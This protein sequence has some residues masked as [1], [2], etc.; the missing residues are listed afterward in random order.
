LS[1][2]DL[3]CW[4][5]KVWGRSASNT[6][7]NTR[8]CNGCRMDK[9]LCTFSF[10]NEITCETTQPVWCIFNYMT[11]LMFKYTLRE[12]AESGC[13]V[14]NQTSFSADTVH[15]QT[16]VHFWKNVKSGATTNSTRDETV[17]WNCAHHFNLHW[18][19]ALKMWNTPVWMRSLLTF[20][21]YSSF[22]FLQIKV[23]KAFRNNI[24]KPL[25]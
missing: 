9:S 5:S 25:L 6:A 14:L 12:E 4:L 11:W 7:V 13:S 24:W 18:F 20:K 3:H 2:L 23:F 17:Q 15:G 19:L 22:F 8:R 21:Q 1:K 10:K 16:G